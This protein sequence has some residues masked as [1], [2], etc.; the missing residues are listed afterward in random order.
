[1]DFKLWIEGYEQ[2]KII[3]DKVAATLHCDQGGSCPL[4]AEEAT[5]EFLKNGI[6]NFVVVEGWVKAKTESHWRQHTWIE[7]EGQK[8]D[9]TFIQFNH[10]G[11]I[12]YV[13]RVKKRYSPGEYMALCAKYPEEQKHL[14][15][16]WAVSDSD[17]TS[18][19]HREGSGL[20]P[21]R[22][23]HSPVSLS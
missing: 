2:S 15:Q 6:Q 22:S 19:L 13:T 3:A 21:L 9:P 5:K 20:I 14:K 23:T 11:E 17:S 7:I 10:L 4:F 18:R 8:I 16:F 1:M 12:K